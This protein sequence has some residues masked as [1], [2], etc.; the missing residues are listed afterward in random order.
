MKTTLAVLVLSLSFATTLFAADPNMAELNLKIHNV[1]TFKKTDKADTFEKINEVSQTVASIIADNTVKTDSKK[2]VNTD[3][4]TYS[5]NKGLV[6]IQD[7]KANIDTEVPALI[8]KSILGRIKS[9][10]ITGDNLE[11]VYFESLKNSGVISLRDL[12]LKKDERQTMIIG[13]QTCT[14]E[15]SSDAV[16]CEQDV[17]LRVTQYKLILA[18]ALYIFQLDL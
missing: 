10:K 1:I 6:H 17:E 7:V 13:D 14:I 18:A 5:I 12:D 16:I 2:S 3:K 9:F 15:R 4:L 11:T 8:D